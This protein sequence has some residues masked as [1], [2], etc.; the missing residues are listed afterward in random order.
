MA[1]EARTRPVPLG[2]D[3]APRRPTRR[4]ALDGVR[5]LAVAAVVAYHLGGG[6]G[7]PV[8]GG[9]LGVDVFFVLSGYLITGLLL[10]EHARAGRIALAGFWLRR[11][12][13]LL[14]AALLVLVAVAAWVW[15]S[16]PPET[17]PARRADLLWTLGYGANWHFLATAQDY[18]AAYTGASP[19]RHAW[20]LA[21]EEQFYLAWPLLVI[22]ALAVGRRRGWGRTQALV[23]LAAAT[24]ASAVAFA[25]LWSASDPS[26]AYYSTL[27]RAQELLAGA[28][29][30]VALPPLTAR[31]PAVTIARPLAGLA[32][33]TLLGAMLLLPDDSPGYFH[34]GALV[35][36]AVTAA[37]LGAIELAPH[38]LVARVLSLPPLVALGRIS[39]GVYLWHWPVIIALPLPPGGAGAINTQIERLALT[40]AA[41][42]ASFLV[43]ERPV[44]TGHLPLIGRSRRRF[45]LAAVTAVALTATITLTATR[46]PPM[47][48]AGITDRADRDCPG[49]QVGDFMSCLKVDAGPAAP[50]LAVLGDSTARA[51]AAGLD[52]TAAREHFS[53]VQAA[54]QRCTVTGLLV[55]P[56]ADRV[57]DAS[58]RACTAMVDRAVDRALDRYHPQVVLVAEYWLHNQ[59]VVVDGVRLRIGSAAYR[60]AVRAR[61]TALV[62]RVAARGGRTVL[63][64]LPPRGESLGAVVAPAR[65]AGRGRGPD[66]TRV[67]RLAYN[68]DLAA[69]VAARPGTS[70]LVSVTDLLCS[71]GHCPA[72]LDGMLARTDG[73]HFTSAYARVLV[74]ALVQRIEATT[75]GSPLRLNR[76]TR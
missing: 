37:L 9:F 65:P 60:A 71:A 35:L 19:L 53:W 14:P 69:V 30:A 27:G 33:V 28:V 16:Q 55:V 46:L 32:L 8:R 41:A 31:G 70:S 50:A 40:L 62:D 54:W 43:V 22:A 26:A 58:A 34:G 10:A 38:A 15:W 4:P 76:P 17:W 24:V 51:L 12:R 6:S 2:T 5:A 47:V 36:C 72:V 13:R 73:V 49:E 11:A 20:S 75:A 7:S 64:E 3:A 63:L 74:P 21:V 61:Y 59:D 18:F 44:L 57:P 39:Y 29:L 67:A 25:A 23:A 68:E 56:P 42:S 1:T 66:P 52:E 48:E 45:A